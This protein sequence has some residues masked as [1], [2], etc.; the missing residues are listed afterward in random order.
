MTKTYSQEIA[1]SYANPVKLVDGAVVNGNVRVKRS[2]IPL[3]GQAVGDTIVI[4]KAVAGESFLY[5]V[6]NNAP[7]LGSTATIAIGIEG[8][9]GKYRVA[10]KKDTVVP[11]LASV[12]GSLAKLTTDE[13]IFITVAAAALPASGTLV[14]DLYF[15]ST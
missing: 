7:G 9:T 5:A 15:A 4:A 12:A 6:I 14:V 8:D 3:A 13:E 10:L 2:T 1:G 11:E